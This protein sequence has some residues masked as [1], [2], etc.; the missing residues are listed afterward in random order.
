MPATSKAQYRFMQGVAHGMKPRGGKGPTK[1][2]AQEFVNATPNPGALPAR[3]SGGG[4]RRRGM[5][6]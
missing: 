4:G 3:S 6:K 1:K 5:M 2:Q